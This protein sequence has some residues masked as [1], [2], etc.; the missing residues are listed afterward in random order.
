[1]LSENIQAISALSI[2]VRDLGLSRLVEC[3]L[4]GRLIMLVEFKNLI[5]SENEKL[6]ALGSSK[7]TK[8]KIFTLIT[9]NI[10]FF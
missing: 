9:K 4:H 6:P 8:S 1:M 10:Y 2:N 7:A 3:I 5:N